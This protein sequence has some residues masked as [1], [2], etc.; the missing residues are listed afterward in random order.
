MKFTIYTDPHQF[1]IQADPILER[2]ED[3]YSL[4]YGVLESI[5]SGSYQNPIKIH[6]WR[7]LRRREKCWRCY[8]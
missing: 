4:F 5:K 3:V 1:A 6:S 2:N 7:C 8:K